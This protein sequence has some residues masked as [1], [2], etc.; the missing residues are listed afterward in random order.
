MACPLIGCWQRLQTLSPNHVPL[1]LTDMGSSLPLHFVAP[2]CLS[3]S[4]CMLNRSNALATTATAEQPLG[5][6]VF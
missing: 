6:F 5:I 4:R 1:P 2:P 3:Q